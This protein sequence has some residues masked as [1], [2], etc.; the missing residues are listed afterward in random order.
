MRASEDAGWPPSR[1]RRS[2]TGFI[3]RRMSGLH[4][5]EATYG[6]RLVGTTRITDV[7]RGMVMQRATELRDTTDRDV[8]RTTADWVFMGPGVDGRLAPARADRE[9][10]EAL[11]GHALTGGSGPDLP[12]VPDVAPRALPPLEVEPWWTEMDPMGHVNHPRYVDWCDEAV[13]RWLAAR[14]VDPI[15]VIPRFEQVVFRSAAVAGGSVRVEA[16]QTGAGAD[17][18]RFDVAITSAGER[19]CEATLVRAHLG[20]AAAWR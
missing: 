20:G 14:G 5:R 10:L 13:A 11:A 9:L 19:V 6:E 18:A 2:G 17:E 3:V 12:S 8:L 16:T 15:G 1:Y 4:L 7:R